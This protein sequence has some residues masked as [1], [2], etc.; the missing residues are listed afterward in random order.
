MVLPGADRGVE[1]IVGG[2]AETLGV[3]GAEAGDRGTIEGR[4][5]GGYKRETLGLAAGALGQ[6][7]EAAHR[8]ERIAKQ[9][10]T[11][12]LRLAGREDVDEAAADR[13]LARFADGSGAR[14]AVAREIVGE[15]TAIDAFAGIGVKDRAAHGVGGRHALQGGVDRG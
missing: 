7:V 11:N 15:R 9:I 13:V 12:R 10:E 5:A 4:L 8:F 1:W 6:R 3:A 14:V 2:H